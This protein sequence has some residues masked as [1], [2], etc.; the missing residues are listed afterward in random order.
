MTTAANF[1][2]AGSTVYN[3]HAKPAGVWIQLFFIEYDGRR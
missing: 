2:E 3:H 1:R